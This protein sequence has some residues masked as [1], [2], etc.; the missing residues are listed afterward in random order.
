MGL[1]ATRGRV[2]L[3]EVMGC[4]ALSE[5]VLD[6]GGLS[7]AGR[8]SCVEVPEYKLLL[9]LGRAPEWALRRQRVFITHPHVDHIGGLVVH[10]ATRALLGMSPPTYVVP[11]VIVTRVHALLDAWRALDGSQLACEVRGVEPGDRVSLSG[12]RHVQA[13]ATRHRVPSVGYA[14]VREQRRLLPELV[15][16]PGPELAAMRRAGRVLEQVSEVVDLAYTGDA[17]VSVLDEPLV[18]RARTLLVEVTFY[19]GRV[20]PDAATRL[21]HI[22]LDQ[23]LDRADELRQE[24]LVFMHRSARHGLH[25]ARAVLDARLPAG[26]R[27][28]VHLFDEL[29]GT[30]GPHSL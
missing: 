9:D 8:V 27:E 15:G 2:K 16:T 20:S 24:R 30:L 22:H 12:R 19:D 6:V 5:R 14:L 13:F 21:G 23:I 26:L 1:L 29:P 17:E 11:A 4:R 18:Q 10:C 25:Q 28:R 3:R 7:V